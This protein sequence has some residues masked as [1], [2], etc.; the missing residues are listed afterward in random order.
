M[1]F[2][3]CQEFWGLQLKEVNCKTKEL[4]FRIINKKQKSVK[5]ILDMLENKLKE[6][7]NKVFESITTDNGIEFLEQECIENSC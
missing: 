5:M 7:F 4:I 3:I 2:F 6:S 1:R